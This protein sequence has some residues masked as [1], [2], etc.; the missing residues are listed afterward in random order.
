MGLRYAVKDPWGRVFVLYGKGHQLDP[1]E[2]F[3]HVLH[4]CFQWGCTK[5]G[6]EEVNFSKVYKHFANYMLRR[7]FPDKHVGFIPQK[8][9]KQSKDSRIMGMLPMFRN[10]FIYLN[11]PLTQQLV[12]EYKEYPFGTTRDIFS[13][14]SRCTRRHSSGHTP[15]TRCTTWTR[16]AA[17]RGLRPGQL[18]TLILGVLRG[19]PDG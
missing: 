16:E 5:A 13:M 6:V 4:L 12:L 8:A 3:R 9:E 14:P 17:Q 7:E 15:P 19:A 11:A 2:M 10:G 1:E 18:D